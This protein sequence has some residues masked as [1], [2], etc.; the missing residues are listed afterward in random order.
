MLV[1]LQ[2]PTFPFNEVK[3]LEMKQKEN[4][5]KYQSPQMVEKERL[6]KW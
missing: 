2:N 1:L 3:L 6:R 4:E 5:L